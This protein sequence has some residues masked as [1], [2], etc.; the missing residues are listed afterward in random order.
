MPPSTTYHQNILWISILQVSSRWRDIARSD[1]PLWTTV[2]L[3]FPH[4]A[5]EFSG[6]SKAMPTRI[7]L[8]ECR[9]EMLRDE[10]AEELQR[11]NAIGNNPIAVIEI[12]GQYKEMTLYLQYLLPKAMNDLLSLEAGLD[13]YMDIPIDAP[14]PNLQILRLRRFLI[15]GCTMIQS[16]IVSL[17]EL[18]LDSFYILNLDKAIAQLVHLR[19]LWV[20]RSCAGY[21]PANQAQPIELPS[22]TDLYVG[23]TVVV[24]LR[25]LRSLVL[26]TECNT[27]IR[28]HYLDQHLTA[29]TATHASLLAF[30][31]SAYP[32]RYLVRITEYIELQLDRAQGIPYTLR[33]SIHQENL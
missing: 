23:D 21:Q 33:F 10:E 4:L 26:P 1:P 32:H 3:R 25:L 13:A 6:Y 5:R 2:N 29:W 15:M 19:K 14:L 11:L 24:C 20:V 28:L 16:C 17:R 22:L 7:A 31:S 12:Y 9:S 27:V 18:Q 8:S 30:L